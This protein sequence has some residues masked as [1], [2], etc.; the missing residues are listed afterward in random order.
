MFVSKHL[1]SVLEFIQFTVTICFWIAQIIIY[2]HCIVWIVE[3]VIMF[4][5][6]VSRYAVIAVI[7]TP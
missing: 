4:Y 2:M 6:Y 5:F 3:N 7:N 1:L